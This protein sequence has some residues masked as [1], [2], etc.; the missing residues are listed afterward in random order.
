M[1]QCG[2]GPCIEV[3]N[4]FR[5]QDV[6]QPAAA[7]AKRFGVRVKD[8]SSPPSSQDNIER[9]RITAIR[10][11]HSDPAGGGDPCGRQLGGHPTRAPAPPIS[12]AGL[13]GL[14]LARVV[15]IRD[16][17]SVCIHTRIS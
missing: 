15:N 8:R 17:T 2:T 1:L 5:L 4:P 13:Q 3:Q 11:V 9:I 10:Q 16:G 7:I 14:K 6:G 12:S